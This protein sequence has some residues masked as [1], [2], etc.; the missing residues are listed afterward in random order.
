MLDQGEDHPAGDAVVRFH[1]VRGGELLL[2][3]QLLHRAGGKAPRLRPVRHQITGGD[4]L[5]ELGLLIQCS[6][7]LRL[8]ADLGAQLI[9]SGWKVEAVGP[10]DSFCG[11]IEHVGG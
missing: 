10:G 5:V 2:A 7:A 1:D 8:S 3:Q 9:G 6:D 11:Q 4:Q